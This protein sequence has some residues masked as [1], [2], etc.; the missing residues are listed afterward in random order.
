[1]QITAKILDAAKHSTQCLVVAS[2][3]NGKLSAT[4]VAINAADAGQLEALLQ[5]EKFGGKVGQTLLLLNP[6]GIAAERLLVL[7]F[8]S[9]DKKGNISADS[10]RKALQKV[11]DALKSTPCTE[12]TLSLGDVNLGDR[13][14]EWQARQVSEILITSQYR[15]DTLKSKPAEAS[16]VPAKITLGFTKDQLASANKGIK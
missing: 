13:D 1:M 8:G 15:S 16:F 6:Q 3:E 12:I 7:G 14:P 9:Q 10:F 4:G 11:P 5:R 2:F